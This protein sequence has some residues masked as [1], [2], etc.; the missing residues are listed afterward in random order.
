MTAVVAEARDI[1]RSM[2]LLD[3]ALPPCD[4]PV[5]H[6]FIPGV[7]A[8]TIFIPAGHVLTGRIHKHPNL[9]IMSQGDLSVLTEDGVVRVQAPFRIVSPAG[10]KRVALAHADTVWTTI[11]RTDE[12]DT[13]KLCDA[14]T[15]CTFEQYERFRL[16][17]AGE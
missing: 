9:N 8:R 5:E 11:C 14:L 3:A 13:E 10:T 15:V 1:R 4:L 2:A 7:Y 17:Q 12:T 6:D 16:E